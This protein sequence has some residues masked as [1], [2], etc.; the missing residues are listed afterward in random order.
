M[1][2]SL[3]LATLVVIAVPASAATPD[4]YTALDRRS[5]T[6]CRAAS[7]LRDAKVGPAVR[8]SDR[9]LVD[10]RTVTGRWPQPHMKNAAASMLCLY[11][12]RTQRAETQE[13]ATSGP[14]TAAIKDI[15]WRAEDIGGRGIVDRSEVTLYLGSDGKVGGRSGCNNYSVNYR[16]E[17]ASL[18]LYPP[19]I[20]TRMMCPPAVMEQEARY[21]TLLESATGLTVSADGALV[22]DTP[23]GPLRFTRS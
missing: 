20:G 8:F 2:R 12:R 1:L 21:R 13:A 16:V 5:A 3:I 9:F 17:G 11:N 4:S 18:K 7:G 23:Q 22:I 6:A 10:A 19:M 14:A 15:W